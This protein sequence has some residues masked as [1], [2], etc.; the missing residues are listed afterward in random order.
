MEPIR[1]LT[2]NVRYDT[3][4]D[5]EHAWE[6]RRELVAGVV[7]YHRPALVGLQEPLAH[8]LADVEAALPGYRFEGVGRKDGADG[9]EFTPVGARTDRL[10]IEATGT[11]WLSPTPGE[12]GSADPDASHPRIVTWS[13]LRDRA[14]DRRFH[15]VNTHF[16]HRSAAARRR[17]ADRLREVVADV[18]GDGPAVVTGDLNAT[19]GSP[20][21]DRLTA[22]DGPGRTLR[23]AFELAAFRHG[24]TVT[25]E[26]FDGPPTR[27]I[28]YV[29]VTEGVDVGQHAV[30]ADRGDDRV[31]S[32]HLPVVAELDLPDDDA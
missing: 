17:S 11:R 31:P 13:R 18:A 15:H 7:R 30:L 28:D 32:D 25:F 14:T 8:Q 12:P 1:A 2:F 29:L 23:D 27:R 9:G 24:P 5:G 4:A 19:P 10:A 3:A 20:P 21:L 16:D 22:P 26:Q 6:H